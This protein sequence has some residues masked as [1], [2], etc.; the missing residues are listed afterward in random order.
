MCR[1][2]VSPRD[3]AAVSDP[4]PPL[5][6]VGH[7]RMGSALF[8]GWTAQGLA[9]SVVLTPSSPAAVSPPHR[10]ASEVEAVPADFRPAFIVVAVK[11][12]VAPDVL[13]A[14]GQRFPAVPL[15]SIMAGKR[16]D[17]L[18][19]LAG[20]E[21]VVRAMPNT[22]ASIGCGISGVFASRAV[23]EAQRGLAGRLLEA[24]GEVVW[25]EREEHLD[26]V[27]AV[28]GSGPAYVFLLA[29]LMERA[30][31]SAGLSAPVARHLARATV[32]GAGRLLEADRQD[33][34]MLRAAVTS[35]GGT[36]ERALAVLM[37]DD[38]WPRLVERA[39]AEAAERARQLAS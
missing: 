27:T 36:T 13:P 37:A 17:A 20:T 19:A 29:E 4:L 1:R 32:S 21:A 39:V 22:P 28:S 31:V 15:L 3:A 6:L 26:A 16:T 5:L 7:G 34:S 30:G 8:A 23:D 18:A 12:Q 35:K 9:P 14:V 24:A 11:P 25:L 10:W 2:G 33:A 38:A